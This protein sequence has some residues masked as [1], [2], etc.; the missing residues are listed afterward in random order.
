MTTRV[1][2]AGLVRYIDRWPRATTG[3]FVAG[4]VS[5]AGACIGSAYRPSG[6]EPHLTSS[7][8]LMDEDSSRDL[9]SRF[10]FA[11]HRP[12]IPKPPRAA[13][14]CPAAVWCWVV[15][16]P[17]W[18]SRTIKTVLDG[19]DISGEVTRRVLPSLKARV[20]RRDPY[21]G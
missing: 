1:N 8:A 20:P 14:A 19:T 11:V 4:Q 17:A 15:H 2:P 5:P 13:T 21:D 7:T 18:F 3:L 16:V 6:K 10:R 9:R 12:G